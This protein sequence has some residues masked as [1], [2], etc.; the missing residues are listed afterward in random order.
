MAANSRSKHFR[1][2]QDFVRAC[3]EQGFETVRCTHGRLDCSSLPEIHVT[4]RR[5]ERLR[6]ETAMEEAAAEAGK[7]PVVLAHRSNGHPWR[8][9]M[10]LDTFF[11]LY[12]AFIQKYPGDPE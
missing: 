4:I 12:R 9:T 2:H 7:M 1:G 3:R 11:L 6:M 5:T 8:I 10:G